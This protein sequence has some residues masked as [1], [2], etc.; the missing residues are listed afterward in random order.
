MFTTVRKIVKDFNELYG[1]EYYVPFEVVH[2]DW[3]YYIKGFGSFLWDS[4][5]FYYDNNQDKIKDHVQKEVNKVLGPVNRIS[6]KYYRDEIKF[7]FDN[8]SDII[9]IQDQIN[10]L[11]GD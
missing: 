10:I 2:K 8:N 7:I 4:E 3:T 11:L 1:S 5:N 6:M 9:G